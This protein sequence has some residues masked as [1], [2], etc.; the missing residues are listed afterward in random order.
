MIYELIENNGIPCIVVKGNIFFAWDPND[1]DNY[2]VFMQKLEEKG[3]ET[4]AQLL[5]DDSN[6]AFLTFING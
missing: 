5:A 1:I 4:F 6:T 2:G 3:I